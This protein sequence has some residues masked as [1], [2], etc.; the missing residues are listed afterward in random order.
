MGFDEVARHHALFRKQV[1][2]HFKVSARHGPSKFQIAETQFQIAKACIQII[3]F[4][5]Q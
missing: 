4:S 5:K 3:F 1:P 2:E